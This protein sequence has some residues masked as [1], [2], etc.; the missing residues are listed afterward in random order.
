MIGTTLSHYRIESELGRGGMGVVY[1]A[2]DTELNR[3]VALKFLPPNA[4]ATD[5]D[6]QRF[7][8]EAQAA[9]ALS[10]PN[11]A[12]VFAIEETEEHAFIAMEFVDG[13]TLRD[14]IEKGP[15][16]VER[17]IE[18]AIE[19]AEGLQV[20]HEHGIVHRD[21]KPANIM[22]A[23][24][25][26]VKIMD[27][28]LAKI[29]A[30][31]MLTQAGSTLG[32]IGYMSPEQARGE[33]IDRRTDIWGLGCVLFEMITGR[34]PFSG[35]YEQAIVYSI[36]NS[37]P[38]ALTSLR[39]GVP[40]ALEGIIAKILAKDPAFRYQHVDEL[41]ADLKAVAAGSNVAM[42]RSMPAFNSAAVAAHAPASM[43]SG[44]VEISAYEANNPSRLQK[45]LPW[46][47][48]A[49]AT[50]AA[51][52]LFVF[53]PPGAEKEPVR[54]LQIDILEASRI[55]D[56]FVLSNDGSRLV[57]ELVNSG[58]TVSKTRELSSEAVQELTTH[59]SRGLSYYA[60]SPTGAWVA[61]RDGPEL[62]RV[63]TSGGNKELLSDSENGSRFVWLSDSELLVE[64]QRDSTLTLTTIQNGVKKVV[65]ERDVSDN[66]RFI[67]SI[68]LILGT[69]IILYSARRED[70]AGPSSVNYDVRAL[71]MKSG[72]DVLLIPSGSHPKYIDNGYITFY[73]SGDVYAAPFSVKSLKVGNSFPL[74]PQVTGSSTGAIVFYDASANGVMVYWPAS[75]ESGNTRMRVVMGKKGES[76]SPFDA[77]TSVVRDPRFSPDGS[78]VLIHSQDKENDIWLLDR[79]LNTVVRL[80]DKA[81][82]DE[83]P[84][85]DPDGR[86]FYY[87]SN[88]NGDGIMIRSNIEN[89]AVRDTLFE[90]TGH[91]HIDSMSP[92]GK[93]IM[94]STSGGVDKSDMWRYDT[95]TGTASI[96]LK[97]PF[98][99]ELGYLSP[100]NQWIVY[101]S[102]VTGTI[103]I[104]LNKFPEMDQRRT[105]TSGGGM[106]PIWTKDGKA[107][108][109]TSE[110][111]LMRIP[112]SNGEPQVPSLVFSRPGAFREST[113]RNYDMLGDGAEYAFV[114]PGSV[115]SSEDARDLKVI[116]GV[117]TLLEQL[118]PAKKK[119]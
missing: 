19:I 5:K 56:M 86:H 74:V 14:L 90:A 98:V 87:S 25:G 29:S 71:D 62:F 4:V 11:I 81:G 79:K 52:M 93:W 119:K 99:E 65:F 48:A 6:R 115:S 40:L 60:A 45:W 68:H 116:T 105:L 49:L 112:L 64:N 3:T 21:I 10:H 109:F 113:H 22:I 53:Q 32:T 55:S 44:T 107:I 88:A 117:R 47:V 102:D 15:I 23:K 67:E 77:F 42:S 118:D 46:G 95:T 36:L 2:T 35:E 58:G 72:E 37:E 24:R 111:N 31:S 83:T 80:S 96:L 28:G 57:Y 76:F 103:E 82:E 97:T 16:K 91:L 17:A 1:R 114:D 41:P 27:F 108:Y 8:R 94:M 89:T 51:L 66:R 110:D 84:V 30:A 12:T 43:H 78:K 100:D 106:A 59:D 7:K 61:F 33:D 50:V 63:S 69:N 73:K 9:A 54:R 18:I 92:D 104:Y 101:Q 38:P 26:H 20:A 34:Q 75:E 13:E 85:W 39:S 70:E